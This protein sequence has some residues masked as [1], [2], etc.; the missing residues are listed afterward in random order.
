VNDGVPQFRLVTGS[1]W[2]GFFGSLAVLWESDP[3]VN[4]IRLNSTQ[5]RP[6]ERRV[7]AGLFASL[8]LHFATGLF[9]YNVP[10]GRLF[11]HFAHPYFSQ[12]Q[13]DEPMV[14]YRLESLNLADYLP[15][16]EPPAPGGAPG[17]GDDP[18]LHA[19]RGASSRDPRVR[20]VS[21]P[22]HP[23]NTGQTILQS[24]SPP[25]LTILRDIPLPNLVLESTVAPSAM[26]NPAARRPE[27][28]AVVPTPYPTLALRPAAPAVPQD[29][30]IAPKLPPLPT[31]KMEIPAPPPAPGPAAKAVAEPP[32]PS[33]EAAADRT[34]SHTPVQ[35]SR[36]AASGKA[37]LVSL[38]L[39]PTPLE[40]EITLPAG[41]RRGEFSIGAIA[42]ASGSPGG[43][44][45]FDAPART[46]GDGNGGDTS[47]ASGV[48]GRGG[49]GA[50][51]DS[52]AAS[53]SVSGDVGAGGVYA[54]GSLSPLP[55]EKLVYPVDETAARLAKPSFIVSSGS[56]GGGG[57]EV[58]GVLHGSKIYTIY[59]PMPGRSWILQ[60]CAQ[61]QRPSDPPPPAVVRLRMQP[62]LVPPAALDQYDFRRL[63][64]H[65]ETRDRSD[66]LDSMIIIHGSI[67][68]DGTVGKLEVLRGLGKAND[69]AAEAAF[70]RWKFSPALRGGSPVA[71]EILV[72]IPAI[73]PGS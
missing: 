13:A 51:T 14:V 67:L 30:A 11:G 58:Y 47:L 68:A 17:R 41:N 18:G 43:S 65:G 7:T 25:K 6:R 1:R 62:Q 71:V 10:L 16:N 31:P 60:F 9:Y 5:A 38:S 70:S 3:C 55:P 28:P 24:D 59:L 52:S 39:N 23:D 27:L 57:L 26:L 15:V 49:G 66:R 36:P 4:P 22:P 21:N 33:A 20:V 44:V 35:A 37:R 34:P 73:A 56:G 29:L 32:V 61:H 48:G 53:L 63:P 19:P 46:D 69:E 54:G 64:I 42:S 45:K 50:G 72:G 40:S 2:R 8:L 12:H